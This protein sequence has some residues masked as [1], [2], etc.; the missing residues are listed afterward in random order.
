MPFS[1]GQKPEIMQLIVILLQ[2]F[3]LKFLLWQLILFLTPGIKTLATPL[4]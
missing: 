1:L 2:V 3:L 4:G